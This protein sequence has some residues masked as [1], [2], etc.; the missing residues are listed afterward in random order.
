MHCF[1]AVGAQE[2]YEASSVQTS[3]RHAVDVLRCGARLVHETHDCAADAKQLGAFATFGEVPVEPGERL[4]DRL[5]IQ[6]PHRG[7]STTIP[8]AFILRR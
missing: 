4:D 5:P 1:A 7:E 6:Q 3:T 2:P 8:K